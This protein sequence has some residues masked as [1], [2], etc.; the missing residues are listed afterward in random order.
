MVS[1][2]KPLIVNI[3]ILFSL[4]FN[5]NLFFAFNDKKP[6]TTKQQVLYGLLSS[7]AA[8]LC[9][10]Y[11][12]E[13]LGETHFDLRMVAI[14]IVTIFGGFL[15][16]I[17]TITFVCAIRIL[18]GG[19]F[20]WI[21]VFVSVA[22]FIV[23][24]LF[25]KYYFRSNSKVLSSI[26]ILL[27]Y[28]SIYIAALYLF[29]D[30]LKMPFYAVYFLAFFFTYISLVL[31]IERL[32]LANKQFDETVYMDKLTTISQMAASIAHEIRNP[33]TTV[34]GFIQFL[35]SDTK[36]PK[37]KQFAPLI[38]Q[39]LERTNKI[40]TNY[41][42]L[43]K[44]AH[45]HLEKVDLDEVLKDSVELLNPF[46]SY[47]NVSINYQSLNSIYVLADEQH[48]KQALL[49]VIKNGIEAIE[50][51]GFVKIVTIVLEDKKFVTVII[52]D[53]GKGMTQEQLDKI[54]LPY[55]TTKTKGTGLGS[56]VTNRLIREMNGKI[57]YESKE[58][59]GTKVSISL[60]LF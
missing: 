43:S 25:R 42:N 19:P 44:P 23:G 57:S 6:L 58:G 14:M 9:M 52:E 40:I 35:Q 20:V 21:G 7:F 36:D 34:K 3:T 41:L 5:A 8:I 39:E 59:K 38:L 22:A 27:V 33:I 31:I 32:I 17:I 51:S 28:F 2:I 29:V 4:T 37:L 12:I 13:S 45:F 56:M 60:P 46:G 49:N 18:I 53:T 1:I 15:P 54:G 55:Y 47:Q 30:F 50:E 10:S 26:N 11:P 24:L 16:G 48:L